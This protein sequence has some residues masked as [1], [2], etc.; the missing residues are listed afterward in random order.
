MRRFPKHLG[1]PPFRFETIMEE[2]FQNLKQHCFK[3]TQK[4]LW[5]DE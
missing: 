1:A 2:Q 3:K 5:I 4:R